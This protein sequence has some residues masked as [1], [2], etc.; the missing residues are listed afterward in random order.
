MKDRI[1]LDYAATTPVD[2]RVMKKMEPYFSGVFGN[3]ESLH[4]FGQEAHKAI[5]EAREAL[6][7]ALGC[8]FREIVF[9]GS[10]TEA[11]N[12]FLRGVAKSYLRV[13]KVNRDEKVLPP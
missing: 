1:Y 6:A 9:T 13:I 11:N 12:I 2:E 5:D 4:F 3:P 7:K 8:D 10:A